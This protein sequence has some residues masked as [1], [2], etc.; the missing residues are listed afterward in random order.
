MDLDARVRTLLEPHPAVRAV[1]LVGSRA[2][3]EPTSLSDWDFV[4]ESDDADALADALPGLVGPLEPVVAQWDR[5]SEE[6]ACYMLLLLDGM[7]VDF[8]V[9]RPPLLE[10]PWE[11]RPETLTA[12]D[13]HFWD[14]ILWLGGKQLRGRDELV[15]S[16]VGGLM[17][18]HLLEPL[19]VTRAPESIADAVAAY[20]DARAARER[21]LGIDVPRR[22]EEAVL[23]RL[24]AAGLA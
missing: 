9:D 8:I 23:P 17:F 14:W 15:A 21:E 12:I 7:K 4:V 18:E 19:G 5:L 1:R 2:R 24:Q 16:M 22:P 10:P 3:G 20:R 11:V 13:A 6:S